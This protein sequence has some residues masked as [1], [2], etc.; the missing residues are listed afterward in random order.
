MRFRLAQ[1]SMTLDYGE[2]L[3]YKFEF[4]SVFCVISILEAATA[5]V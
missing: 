3:A 2:L 5:V 1:R 4:F